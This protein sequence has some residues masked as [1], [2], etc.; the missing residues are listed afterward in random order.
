[1]SARVLSL[2]VGHAEPNPAKKVGLT[3]PG[4][5]YHFQTKEALMLGLVE[6][7][8]GEW[9]QRMRDTA[10]IEPDEMSTFDRHRIYVQALL[11]S[12]MSRADFWTYSAAAYQPSLS[13]SWRERFRPWLATDGL[14][15]PAQALLDTARFATDGAFSAQA[16]GVFP[17]EELGAVREIAIRLINEAEE[18]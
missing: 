17:A 18:L 13:E 4:L 5:M 16:T 7:V 11:T 6:F 1:M 10:G 9:A 8:A 3:K 15:A 2:N 14:S 12:D